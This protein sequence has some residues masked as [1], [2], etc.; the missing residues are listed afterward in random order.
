MN[1][2]A[3]VGWITLLAAC[4]ADRASAPPPA[5]APAGNAAEAG[6]ARAAS[7]PAAPSSSGAP[8]YLGGV[9]LAHPETTLR[10]ALAA[11]PQYLPPVARDLRGIVELG[12]GKVGDI[13]ALDRPM[14]LR[15][16]ERTQKPAM[17]LTAAV[18]DGVDVRAALGRFRL[19][20]ASEG[21]LEVAPP[22]PFSADLALS[23]ECEVEMA[24]KPRTVSCSTVEGFLTRTRSQ[25]MPRPPSTDDVTMEMSGDLVKEQAK[26]DT[27]L[28]RSAKRAD[29]S[30]GDA[31]GRAFEQTFI[32]GFV[33]DLRLLELG[34]NLS[35][36]TVSAGLTLDW[37]D[38][39]STFAR[40]LGSGTAPAAPPPRFFHLP[41]D[42]DSAFFSLGVDASAWEPIKKDFVEAV[43]A[44]ATSKSEYPEPIVGEARKW[45]NQLFFTGGGWMLAMG[46]RTS[47]IRD[48]LK[49]PA[50]GRLSSDERKIAFERA[51]KEWFIFEVEE[52]GDEVV[53]KAKG[54]FEF[55]RRADLSAK[56][57]GSASSAKSSSKPDEDLRKWKTDVAPAPR[58]LPAAT[59]HLAGRSARTDQPK[60]QKLVRGNHIL[61]VPEGDH[62]W[63]G[64]ADDEKTIVEHLKR[65]LEGQPTSG[66][67]AAR[68]GIEGLGR[69][70]LVAGGFASLSLFL[71]F[72]ADWAKDEPTILKEKLDYLATIPSKGSA[73]Y[74]FALRRGT[75]GSPR[76][77]IEAKSST[78]TLDEII[79][80]VQRFDK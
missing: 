38:G 16:F 64:I 17:V 37:L 31:T 25:R 12:V 65:V 50:V 45:L 71:G 34:A 76:L 24:A 52:P 67:L 27:T 63:I 28:E 51:G 15:F 68:R 47:E 22:N 29:D 23:K 18:R 10:A 80:Y 4:G 30:E 13:V 3:L 39:R 7:R 33:D 74:F 35:Q 1:K 79:G 14:E 69:T 78:R 62:A 43:L 56:S 19:T 75:D 57:K 36:D 59:F 21:R 42:S 55:T 48:L 72:G 58:G 26:K 44:D 8:R 61:V 73:P 9:R 5:A 2:I 20:E 53:A 32:K 70:P 66:T 40:I 77:T 49:N 41:V 54:V 46:R 6:S 60:N 11:F